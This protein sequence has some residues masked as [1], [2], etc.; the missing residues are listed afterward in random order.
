[1]K[2]VGL[3]GGIPKQTGPSDAAAAAAD[4]AHV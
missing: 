1:V 4:M 3:R 2:Q